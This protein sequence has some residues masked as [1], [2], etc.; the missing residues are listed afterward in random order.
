MPV[1]ADVCEEL[2]FDF[3]NNAIIL[4]S[5]NVLTEINGKGSIVLKKG[6]YYPT[7]IRGESCSELIYVHKEKL[8]VDY[9]NKLDNV[10]FNNNRRGGI[11]TNP[12]QPNEI[13]GYWYDVEGASYTTRISDTKVLFRY[14][15][16]NQRN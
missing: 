8:R 3:K 7:Y 1:S 13:I 5:E 6:Y 9:G 2:E 14:V 15:K 4:Y 10:L 16:M 11:L 12:H